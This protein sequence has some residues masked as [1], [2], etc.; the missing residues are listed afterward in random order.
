MS[1]QSLADLPRVYQLDCG[2]TFD[3][4]MLDHWMAQ[5]QQSGDHVAIQAKCCPTCRQQVHTSPRY[6]EHVKR[7]LALIDKVKVEVSRKYGLRRERLSEAE[8]QEVD[9]AMGGG[10]S[11]GG[12]WFACP[13]GHPYYI[14]ECGGAMV[15]ATCPECGERIGGGSH[16]LRIDN[17]Y[18]ADFAGNGPVPSAWPGMGAP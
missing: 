13:N 12:R 14:G 16:R 7:Q 4:A 9:R 5:S 17:Q 2:H 3:L 18:L 1:L 15:E 11:S 8:R 6:G 10:Q